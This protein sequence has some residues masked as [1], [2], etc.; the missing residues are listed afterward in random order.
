MN[1]GH[2]NSPLSGVVN[3]FSQVAALDQ[4]LDE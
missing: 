3:K 1:L 2:D 4:F